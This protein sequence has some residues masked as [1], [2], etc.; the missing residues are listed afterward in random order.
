MR[1]ISVLSGATGTLA[2]TIGYMSGAEA[3]QQQSCITRH[4]R[5]ETDPSQSVLPP[6]CFRLLL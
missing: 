5:E 6:D 2:G 4:A 3:L 1:F